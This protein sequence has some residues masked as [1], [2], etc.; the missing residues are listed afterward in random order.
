MHWN[1]YYTRYLS[2]RMPCKYIT[3][4]RWVYHAVQCSNNNV[5]RWQPK[6]ITKRRRPYHHDDIC[7]CIRGARSI[8]MVFFTRRTLAMILLSCFRCGVVLLSG[9]AQRCKHTESSMPPTCVV[10]MVCLR[11]F[12][13][14]FSDGLMCRR[15]I[16]RL[17]D[18]D[19]NPKT[20]RQRQ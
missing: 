15:V 19:K 5:S 16:E 20:Q 8:S 2:A 6:T 14:L 17:T 13:L 1:E 9:R 11:S 3:H 10:Y 4:V 7:V 12:Y 18:G